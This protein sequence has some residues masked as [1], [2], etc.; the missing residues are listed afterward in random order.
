MK[1]EL[2]Q[3]T[4][5]GETY[6]Q[7]GHMIK[8][9][10]QG[11]RM[12]PFSKL[13]KQLKITQRSLDI[14]YGRLK[15]DGALDIK[16]QSGVFVKNPYAGGTFLF[17]AAECLFLSHKGGENLRLY[18]A[19]LR[20]K[21]HH[22][23][24]Q[25][26]LEIMLTESPDAQHYDREPQL[27]E[28]LSREN[29]QKRI[30]GAFVSYHITEQ[31]T[32]DM[33]NSLDIPFVDIDGNC[34]KIFDCMHDAKIMVEH[35]QKLGYGKILILTNLL[36]KNPQLNEYL[37]KN[38]NLNYYYIDSNA[39]GIDLVECGINYMK[40]LIDSGEMPEAFAVTDDYFCQGMLIGAYMK[41]VNLEE[42]YGIITVS[43]QGVPI[44]SNTPVMRLNHCWGKIANIASEIMKKKLLK[45]KLDEPV[46]VYP[47]LEP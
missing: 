5:P 7:L 25:S 29:N 34:L 47:T 21:I 31:E 28:R 14:A 1:K 18:F 46:I 38:S 13:L 23:F 36:H 44:H 26:N 2:A 17:I 45:E 10:S 4:K 37:K 16:K 39:E 35:L 43:Q 40:S 41:G 27:R 42:E 9:M 12:P 19:E 20:R 24:P 22:Y 15:E 33:F 3:T 6:I 11:D 30:L 8:N 32:M